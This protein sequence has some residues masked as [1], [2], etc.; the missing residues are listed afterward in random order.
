MKQ[1]GVFYWFAAP[2]TFGAV[3][4][5]L[6]PLLVP[7]RIYEITGSMLDTGIALSC[8]GVC[9]LFAPIIGRTVDSFS[10]HGPAIIFGLTCYT[11]SM[12]IFGNA[13]S[14]ASMY[15]AS[16]LLGIGSIT[17]MT[18]NPTF[19]IA[20]KLNRIT[21]SF[22]LT[23]MNQFVHLGAIFATGLSISIKHLPVWKQFIMISV[24]TI[25]ATI[26]TAMD[27]HKASKQI[28]ID[29]HNAPKTE[30]R[31]W[32]PTFAA[33]LI[34]V[35]IAMVASTNQIVYG[36]T[37]FKTLFSIDHTLIASVLGVSSALS[38]LTLDLVNR[39]IYRTCSTKIWAIGLIG[40]IA[41]AL[42]LRFLTHIDTKTAYLPLILHLLFMQFMSVIDL[43]KPAIASKLSLRSPAYTQGALLFAT[44]IGYALGVSIGGFTAEALKLSAVFL[45]VS[46]SASIAL[47]IASYV[48]FKQNQ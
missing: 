31:H 21:E 33:F 22:Y 3:Q 24:F 14:E 48:S 35:C 15:A 43:V 46:T 18:I 26:T 32:N 29:K 42:S 8:V 41:V 23:R 36:P 7:S 13:V 16:F 34:A 5:V 9:G 4:L 1:F 28:D 39:T 6:L 17:I 40:Y 45:V 44:T 47:L 12:A 25:F 20:A 27:V 10:L 38:L 2:F 30:K 37:L 19:I 11:F